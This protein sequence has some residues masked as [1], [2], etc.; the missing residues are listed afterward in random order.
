MQPIIIVVVCVSFCVKTYYDN[1]IHHIYC[2]KKPI[3]A[4]K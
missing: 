4:D 2:V 1:V 3:V